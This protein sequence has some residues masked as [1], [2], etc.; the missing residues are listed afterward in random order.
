[1][2]SRQVPDLEEPHSQELK[3][4]ILLQP[5]LVY[6]TNFTHLYSET[7]STIVA[8]QDQVI[9]T[10]L[11]EAKIIKKHVPSLMCR[12]C[13]GY[14]ETIVHLMAA[15]PSLACIQIFVPP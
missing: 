4:Y 13:G 3:S 14:E 6:S 9:A 8:I 10:R 5:V 12:L 2:Q 7:E 1:M 15:W 11:I